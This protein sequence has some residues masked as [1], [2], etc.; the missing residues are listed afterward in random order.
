[1]YKIASMS[2]TASY[3]SLGPGDPAPWFSQRSTNN[4][5]FHF[6]TAAGRYL[7]LCFFGRSQD[8][9][10]MKALKAVENNRRCFDDSRASFFGVTLDPEDETE[11]RVNES[12]PGIRFFWDF[13]GTISRAYGAIPIDGSGPFRHFWAVI[14]PT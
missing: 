14:D 8:P 12:L 7:I 6:D 5:R 9:P 11:L 13:D 3:A 10:A 4:P 1:M 2:I